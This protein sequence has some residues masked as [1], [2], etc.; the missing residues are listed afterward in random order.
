MKMPNK[1]GG[2]SAAPSF[3]QQTIRQLGQDRSASPQKR[4]RQHSGEPTGTLD[5]IK[6]LIE[7]QMSEFTKLKEEFQ[8]IADTMKT[9]LTSLKDRVK[10]LEE[11]TNRKE[12]EL[13]S[14][15]KRLKQSEEAVEALQKQ[16]EENEVISR[17]P[18]LIFSGPAVEKSASL[19]RPARPAGDWGRFDLGWV[20]LSG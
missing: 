12:E 8:C 18:T 5:Q 20:N 9:E 11:H 19:P 17:L 2:S 14:M 7:T 15:E 6:D 4:R 1:K 3:V 13:Q 10:D 16:L